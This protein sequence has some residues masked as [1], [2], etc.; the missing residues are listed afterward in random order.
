MPGWVTQ[1]DR[2]AMIEAFEK[3]RKRNRRKGEPTVVKIA[4]QKPV[5]VSFLSPEE[6]EARREGIDFGERQNADR[7]HPSYRP[8]QFSLA[9]RNGR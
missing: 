9:R 1:E 2:E 7:D 5:E 3:N 4:G 8:G 6:L